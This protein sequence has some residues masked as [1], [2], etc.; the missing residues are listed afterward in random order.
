MKRLAPLIVIALLALGGWYA[1]TSGLLTG[2]GDVG[3]K[4]PET[5]DVQLPGADD[6]GDAAGK[7]ARGAEGGAKT[8]A[9]TLAGLDPAVW[10]MV[11]L[12]IGV[13]AIIWVIKNPKRLAIALGLGVVA[14]LLFI[15]G[16]G[17]PG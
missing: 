11:G 13:A 10:R 1:W 6:V 15:T 4:K 2:A 9:D 8:A 17:K 14:L 12:G 16:G 3:A 7:A 5:P